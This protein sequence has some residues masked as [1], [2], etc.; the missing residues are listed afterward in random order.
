MIDEHG[1]L[2]F[3]KHQTTHEIRKV[4]PSPEFQYEWRWDV[5]LAQNEPSDDPDLKPAAQGWIL[6]IPPRCEPES[7]RITISEIGVQTRYLSASRA[8]VIINEALGELFKV[9][10]KVFYKN[11][12][13]DNV[14]RILEPKRTNLTIKMRFTKGA[15]QLQRDGW[16]FR[17]WDSVLIRLPLELD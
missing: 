8:E 17:S 15:R 2:I 7:R 3:E 14:I 12:I 4:E 13:Q 10:R 16:S 9:V 1:F 11:T 6:V 5:W